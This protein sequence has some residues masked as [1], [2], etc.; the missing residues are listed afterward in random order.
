MSE[1]GNETR[2]RGWGIV[3]YWGKGKGESEKRK[4]TG[5]AEDVAW[6]LKK[7]DAHIEGGRVIG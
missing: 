5:G 4:K 2:R 1:R 7:E 3:Q 6:K